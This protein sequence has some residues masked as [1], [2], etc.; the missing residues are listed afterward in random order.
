MASKKKVAKARKSRGSSGLGIRVIAGAVAL[1]AAAVGV[2]IL[3]AW[4]ALGEAADTRGQTATVTSQITATQTKIAALKSG[5]KSNA[6]ALLAQARALDVQLPATVDKATLAAAVQAAAQGYGLTIARMDP[7]APDAA[8][9]SSG[10]ATALPFA[11]EVSGPHAQVVTFLEE[12]TSATSPLGL[13]TIAGVSVTAADPDTTASFTL[14][15]HYATSP[16]LPT[17]APGVPQP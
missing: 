7:A 1:I 8:A 2:W 13:V 11:V 16:T 14:A 6:T 15:A 5:E 10:A 12:L 4:P 9:V 17:G 3:W